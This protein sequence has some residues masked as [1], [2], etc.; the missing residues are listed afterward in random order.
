LKNILKITLLFLF[1]FALFA[2]DKGYTGG[3][4]F[5]AMIPS[6]FFTGGAETQ[7]VDN[8]AFENDSKFG[9][10]FGMTIRKKFTESLSVESGLRF[11]QRN[12]QTTIDSLSNS[13]FGVIDYRIIGYEIPLKGL[14]TLRASDNSIFIAGFGAQLDL[15]PSDVYA[16]NE[17]W[18]VEMRR[19]S[20][21]QGSFLANLGWELHVINVGYFYGG[22]SYNQPFSDPFNLVIGRYNSTFGVT[23]LG[24]NGRYLSVDLRY[25]FETKKSNPNRK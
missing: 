3:F 19:K 23:N 20:W 25:Y 11:V 15:Y 6:D 16:Y 12:Y 17:D 24:V 2:Q 10:V 21:I 14:V 4:Q 5:K 7:T 1:P 13:Y 9:Y 22:F 8:I 18:Q